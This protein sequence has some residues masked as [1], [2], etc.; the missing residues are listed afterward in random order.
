MKDDGAVP[1]RPVTVQFT[2]TGPSASSLF[3]EA[4]NALGDM[5]TPI[6]TNSPF[7]GTFIFEDLD[8]GNFS[9]RFYRAR[10]P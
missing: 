10:I 1:I 6:H 3:I 7:D 9:N 5:W 2:V 8:T 4:V